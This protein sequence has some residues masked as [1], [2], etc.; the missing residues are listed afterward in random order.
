MAATEKKT[1]K[2]PTFQYLPKDRAKK[3]KK[4]WIENKKI[5][6]QWKAQKRRE[7]LIRQPVSP[8][9]GNP[10]QEHEATKSRSDSTSQSHFDHLVHDPTTSQ[11]TPTAQQKGRSGITPSN[12][13]KSLRELKRHA[14]SPSSLH[15]PTAD[16]LHRKGAY[17]SRNSHLTR[18]KR[19][20]GCTDRGREKGQPNMT[21]RMNV[22]LEKIKRNFS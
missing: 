1:K 22:M 11:W 18:G 7:G 19:D 8:R 6:S 16:P 5:K 20:G 15:A 9:E 4:S 13:K 14:Y 17:S 21:L 2:P 12:G 3:L 10:D